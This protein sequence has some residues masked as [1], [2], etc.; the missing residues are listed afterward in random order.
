[1]PKNCVI[2]NKINVIVEAKYK[3]KSLAMQ[4]LAFG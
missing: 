4:Y 3:L 2:P 1:M